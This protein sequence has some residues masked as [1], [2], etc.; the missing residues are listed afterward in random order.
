MCNGLSF[1]RPEG[2]C[3]F[4][5]KNANAAEELAIMLAEKA[6]TDVCPRIRECFAECLRI[7]NSHPHSYPDVPQTENADCVDGSECLVHVS[8][9]APYFAMEHLS[10]PAEL[11]RLD[12]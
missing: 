1:S 3:D 2:E 9:P 8:C 6:G 11:I 12:Q 10:V 5:A 4:V 7:S